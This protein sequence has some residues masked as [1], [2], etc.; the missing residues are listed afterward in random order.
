ML[1]ATPQPMGR[2]S[3]YGYLVRLGEANGYPTPTVATSYA[4]YPRGG[5]FGLGSKLNGI[6]N[7]T[8]VPIGELRSI[9][10]TG[11]G[12]G[13]SAGFSLLGLD[14]SDGCSNR[15]LRPK[16]RAIC[17]QCVVELGYIEAF[18]DLKIAIACP[19]HGTAALQ[20]CPKCDNAI[21]W[22]RPGLLRCR[23]GASFGSYSS[24]SISA[25]LQH[26]LAAV[27]TR[28]HGRKVAGSES[29]LPIQDLN[30]LSFKELLFLIHMLGRFGANTESSVSR[31][32]GGVDIDLDAAANALTHWPNGFH[33]YLDELGR[34]FQTTRGVHVG[35][36]KQ[37]SP[38]YHSV[39]RH[40]QFRS[41]F[42]FLREEF[43]NFGATTWGRAVIDKKLYR[44]SEPDKPLRFISVAEAARR[45]HISPVTARKW[46]ASGIIPCQSLKTS[47]TKRFV[48]DS[49]Y[50]AQFERKPGEIL[51]ERQ[52]AAFLGIPVS[53]LRALKKTDHYAAE[54]LPRIMKGYHQTD[55]VAFR[56]R[57]AN[58]ANGVRIGE[59]CRDDQRSLRSVLKWTK[60]GLAT[61][62]DLFCAYLDG[63][64]KPVGKRSTDPLSVYFDERQIL[65]F[66]DNDRRAET[67]GALTLTQAAER[68]GCSSDCI[69]ELIERGLLCKK[70]RTGWRVVCTDSVGEFRERF[71]AVNSLAREHSTTVRRLLRISKQTGVDILKIRVP[72]GYTTSFVERQSADLLSFTFRKECDER[73]ERARA[74]SAVARDTSAVKKYIGR[75]AESGE[76]LPRYGNKLNKSAIAKAA[77]IDRNAIYNIAEIKRL[78][79]DR[80]TEDAKEHRVRTETE[81]TLLERYLTRVSGVDGG[82]SLKANGKPHK[83]RI[84]R[85]AGVDRSV[86]YKNDAANL[87]LERFT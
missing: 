80:D 24:Q 29:Q 78:L 63:R 39:F 34:Y 87:L 40:K 47:G 30:A 85:E 43:V 32:N 14:V 13:S 3:L 6:S 72:R 66:V 10:Y 7:V 67:V 2:E 51:E 5:L 19:L 21:N 1:V 61:K 35:L 36:R 53:V 48:I 41:A 23:C 28:L 42:E 20:H 57:L 81:M 54:N 27:R 74:E 8:G 22:L 86:F 4:G 33:Q 69:S 79:S 76:A 49:E 25:S 26:L 9:G 62:I 38:F 15:Y 68:I 50:I 75:L 58:A 56:D 11:Q 37:F 45:L 55:L 83:L 70:S 77:G 71:V 60:W 17:P 73:A 12:L 31:A 16:Q 65:A 82:L 18:W 46:C 44:A 59:P 52:A 64:V 84:A